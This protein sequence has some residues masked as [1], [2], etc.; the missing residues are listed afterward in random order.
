MLIFVAWNATGRE[1]QVGAAEI[2]NLDGW[3]FLGRDAGRIV[4]LVTVQALVFAFEQIPSL[5][6]IESLDIP[7][8]QREVLSVVF[9]VAARTLLT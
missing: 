7:L 5:F 2:L 8:D 6:V 9:G 1:T 3:A 4:A